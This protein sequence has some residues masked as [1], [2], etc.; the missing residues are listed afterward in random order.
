MVENFNSASKDIFY[1]KA[2]DLTGD[3]REH[4]E[5]SALALHLITAAITYLNTVMIQI[6]LRD[7]AWNR[8][9][10][11]A[12]RRGLSALFWSPLNLYGRFELDMNNHL[13]ILGGPP[14]PP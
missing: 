8:R 14:V 2:G 10:T 1:G 13:D 11:P 12:D 4:L 3:D 9:L 6:V 5:V 7:P